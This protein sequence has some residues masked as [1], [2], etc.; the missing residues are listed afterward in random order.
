M[1]AASDRC[2]HE[3]TVRAYV[4]ILALLALTAFARGQT[5]LYVDDN[6]PDGGDGTTE[7]R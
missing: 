5:I 7:R 4:S 1:K 2:A 6:A 3:R